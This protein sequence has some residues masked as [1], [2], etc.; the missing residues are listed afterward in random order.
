MQLGFG[1]VG[2][3]FGAL[4]VDSGDRLGQRRRRAGGLAVV[5]VDLPDELAVLA[6]DLGLGVGVGNRTDTDGPVDGERR[7]AELAA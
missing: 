7:G 6:S 5:L 1:W 3:E 2:G 4:R